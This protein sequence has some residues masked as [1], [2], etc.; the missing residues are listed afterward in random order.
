MEIEKSSCTLP[1]LLELFDA[2]I[3]RISEANAK[4]L[5]E[6]SSKLNAQ[7]LSA[8]AEAEKQRH[9]AEE[10]ENYN[11]RLEKSCAGLMSTMKESS[12]KHDSLLDLIENKS[13]LISSAQTK[14]FELEKALQ[15]ATEQ[16]AN[17]EIKA[18]TDLSTL[19][20]AFEKK[21]AEAK[22]LSASLADK[23]LLSLT[24]ELSEVRA[25][26]ERE[27]LEFSVIRR[28]YDSLMTLINAE[29]EKKAAAL[30]VS[31]A[32]SAAVGGAKAV[33]FATGS[34]S[35]Q[36]VKPQNQQPITLTKRQLSAPPPPPPPQSEIFRPGDFFDDE[37]IA[38]PPNKAAPL[39]RLKRGGI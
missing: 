17:L 29:R 26:R 9:R 28:K 16:A 10:A 18:K 30:A 2:E 33:S 12:Q 1:S 23:A 6:T 7:I 35:A 20:K 8:T 3:A 38:S 21:A 34:T 24:N 37:D 39:K 19:T 14:C 15:K 5:L 13:V 25:A 22:A 4:T 27:A 32:M 36:S 11:V 31:V